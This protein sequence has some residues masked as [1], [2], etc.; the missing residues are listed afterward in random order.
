MKNALAPLCLVFF[1]G[2]FEIEQS[3]DLQNDLSG[4]AGFHLDVDAEP[5][6]AVMAQFAREMEGKTGPATAEEL[7]KAKADFRKAKS[8][9]TG[10][11]SRAEIEASLPEG[12]TLIDHA[13]TERELGMASDFRFGFERLS[14]L[15]G[16]RLPS[17]GSD[18]M[19]TRVIDSP[20][21]AL[22]VSEAPGTITI[23]AKAQN[24]AQSVREHARNAPKLQAATERLVRDAFGRMRVTY[25]ITAPFAVVSH[26]ATRREGNTLIWQYDM[27]TFERMQKSKR[28]DDAQLRVTYRR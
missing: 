24:P 6:I 26:N 9:S 16:V 2:C 14:Q 22:E 5:L 1:A 10:E 7:A 18:P 12:V 11:V 28:L 17:Q 19:E 3:I 4:T 15:V 20:F 25:R 8:R 27:E 21:E 23:R 13:I